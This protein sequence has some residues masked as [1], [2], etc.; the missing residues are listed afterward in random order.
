MAAF[1]VVDAMFLPSR[2]PKVIDRRA[3]SIG[4]RRLTCTAIGRRGQ[5]AV[6]PT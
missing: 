5:H 2:L 4:A 3:G 6:Y 1:A